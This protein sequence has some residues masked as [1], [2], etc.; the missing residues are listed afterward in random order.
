MEREGDCD[1]QDLIDALVS[2]G[3]VY[4]DENELEQFAGQCKQQLW[5]AA[6]K[7][8]LITILPTEKCNFRCWYCYE[9]FKH[10]KMSDDIQQCS[11]RFIEQQIKDIQPASL[12]VNWFGGEPLLACDVIENISTQ[13]LN[14]CRQNSIAYHA[15]ITTNGYLLTPECVQRLFNLGVNTYQITLDGSRHDK[16]G[17]LSNG[18][19]NRCTLAQ[20]HPLNHIGS[21]AHDV[22]INENN[23]LWQE[24]IEK[25]FHRSNKEFFQMKPHTC[26]QS[27]LGL[28]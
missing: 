11:V 15:Q 26:F 27:T 7:Q 9:D 17:V 3:A 23:R 20:K 18:E 5:E 22:S 19:L 6:Q 24:Y 8:L 25:D 4:Q 28:K 1:K 10:G 16:N 13:L 14:V 21:I 12:Q 2:M